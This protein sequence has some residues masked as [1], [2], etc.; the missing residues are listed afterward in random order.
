ML[1]ENQSMSCTG[2]SPQMMQMILTGLTELPSITIYSIPSHSLC[3][4]RAL[5]VALEKDRPESAE[6]M[7]WHPEDTHQSRSHQVSPDRHK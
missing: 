3:H 2:A 1:L 7:P 5:A 4:H 6:Q